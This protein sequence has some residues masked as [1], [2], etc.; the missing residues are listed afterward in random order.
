MVTMIQIE[1]KTETTYDK[2]LPAYLLSSAS[3]VT[4]PLSS[5]KTTYPW[6]NVG[7]SKFPSSSKFVKFLSNICCRMISSLWS[8]KVLKT[9]AN[10]PFIWKVAPSIHTLAKV[11]IVDD[12]V[13]FI[14]NS[15]RSPGVGQ[16]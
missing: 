7:L 10:T 14:L 6:I 1:D 15:R 16:V 3:Q 11:S 12:F 8:T 13:M 4:L 5:K 2:H 9:V